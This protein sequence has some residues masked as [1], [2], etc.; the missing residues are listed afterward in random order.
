M[1]DILHSH[2]SSRSSSR[3]P[4]P[5]TTNLC[6]P[7]SPQPT[8]QTTR[9]LSP[10]LSRR[11]PFP[12]CRCRSSRWRRGRRGKKSGGRPERPRQQRCPSRGGPWWQGG[13]PA[14]EP[15]LPARAKRAQCAARA[16]TQTRSSQRGGRG[17]R[18]PSR[19]GEPTAA[20]TSPG[21]LT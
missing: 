15:G 12:A 9:R 8:T 4:S 17:T 13:R 10:S 1:S 19:R 11:R 6:F 18:S 7:T 14:A 16:A 20:A 2:L 5:A 3:L 21:L